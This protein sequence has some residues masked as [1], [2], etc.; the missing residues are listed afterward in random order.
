MTGMK[1]NQKGPSDE[2]RNAESRKNA[3][4][5]ID[6]Q[7]KAKELTRAAAEAGDPEKRQRLLNEA[8]EQEIASESYGK[9]A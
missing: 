7:K 4:K 6:A 1:D 8:L 3:Q 5:S 2:E 9:T